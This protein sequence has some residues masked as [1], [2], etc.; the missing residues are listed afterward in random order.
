MELPVSRLFPDL[1]TPWLQVLLKYKRGCH[2][3]RV[4]EK[5]DGTQIS[6][7]PRLVVLDAGWPWFSIFR[8]EH[9]SGFVL[10][11][12]LPLEGPK[13]H[14]R[15]RHSR[16]TLNP[17]CIWRELQG[18]EQRTPMVL[19][20]WLCLAEKHEFCADD[21]GLPRLPRISLQLRKASMSMRYNWVAKWE[22][23]EISHLVMIIR[24]YPYPDLDD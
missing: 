18:A 10:G 22:A 8:L 11:G 13:E 16:L 1:S 9:L 2:I 5:L 6:E 3:S 20:F 24:N 23:V 4:S 7:T 14:T 21:E 12:F 15:S 17:T 19:G